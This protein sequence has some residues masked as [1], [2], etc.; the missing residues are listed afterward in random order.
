MNIILFVLVPLA[1]I[2]IIVIPHVL[3]Q[4]RKTVMVSIVRPFL[5]D[6]QEAIKDKKGRWQERTGE[7]FPPV[8]IDREIG[9]FTFAAADGSVAALY[10]AEGTHATLRIFLTDGETEIA[11]TGGSPSAIHC[12]GKDFGDTHY[13]VR[14]NGPMLCKI[15]NAIRFSVGFTLT[16]AEEDP[17]PKEFARPVVRKPL[18]YGRASEERKKKRKKRTRDL[19]E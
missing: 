19:D 16:P 1:L 2:A 14:H 18:D 3:R 10:R 6:L 8:D 9:T 4:R 13:E 15:R 12:Q 11:F 17:A 5:D 7:K